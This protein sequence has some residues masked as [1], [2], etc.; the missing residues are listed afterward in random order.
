[1]WPSLVVTSEKL[2]AS[3]RYVNG[4]LSFVYLYSRCV[5]EGLIKK[6][7]NNLLIYD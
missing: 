4:K 6:S 3:G 1:M 5:K 7:T 2:P